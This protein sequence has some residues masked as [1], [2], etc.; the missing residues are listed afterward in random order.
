MQRVRT[1]CSRLKK[2]P[3]PRSS[4]ALRALVTSLRPN[5][6]C[7]TFLLVFSPQRLLAFLDGLIGRRQN[8]MANVF[9]FS[10]LKGIW[11][12]T[13]GSAANQR[14]EPVCP[15]WPSVRRIPQ[16]CPELLRNLAASIR[17]FEV[18]IPSSERMMI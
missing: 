1:A 17:G 14:R 12:R 5:P 10:L 16:T 7:H 18:S 8:R 13:S 11:G 4:T 9:E 3:G 15:S 6:A 2:F